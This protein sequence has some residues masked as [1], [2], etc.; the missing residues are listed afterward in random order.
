MRLLSIFNFDTYQAR[1]R[2]SSWVIYLVV[3]VG[4][5]EAV[6]RLPIVTAHLPR[7]EPTLWHAAL[8]Q[9][10]IDYLKAFQATAGVDILFIG[11]STVQAGVDPQVFDTVRGKPAASGPGAF[12]AA[13]EGLPP[14]GV[15]NFL[16]IYLRYAHPK[17]IIYGVTPQDFNSNSPWAQDVTDRVKH[18]LLAQA[19]ARRGWQGK[20]I[21]SLLEYSS[22]YR[23]RFVLHQLLLQGGFPP[24]SPD[25]YFDP[26]GYQ[27]VKGR[28]SDVPEADRGIYHNKAGV[29]N[30]STRGEQL[31]SMRDLIAYCLAHN[32]Q[33]ILVNMPLADDYYSNFDSPEDYQTYIASLQALASEYNLPLWDM[34]HLPQASNFTDADFADFNH[35]NR[36][37]AEKL[38]TL[39]AEHYTEQAKI[40]SKVEVK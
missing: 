29:M 28:L 17:I 22:F 34:E 38:S 10:K 7:P 16:E 15:F 20:V 6:L 30:Y 8:I 5:A 13:I 23:Y 25:V 18:S 31:E 9:A 24:P 32:I 3:F 37:G 33:L 36:P 19:E 39:L 21:A 11:N 4:L 35:L 27:A 12:N 40:S 1:W 2:L 14:Y 26:R